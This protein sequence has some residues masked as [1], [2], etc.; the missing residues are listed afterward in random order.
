MTILIHAYLDKIFDV[1]E[2]RVSTTQ[3][4][5]GISGDSL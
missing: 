4:I 3:A 2:Q 1:P 5:K